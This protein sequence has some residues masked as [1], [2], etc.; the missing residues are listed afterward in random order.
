M[1]Y[2]MRVPAICLAFLMAAA[3]AD[4]QPQ[5]LR[6]RGICD[7]FA[8]VALGP[9]HFV[10]AEDEHDILAIY[11]CGNAT[12]VATVDISDF[13]GNRKSNGK[14]K[15]ADIEGAARIGNRIY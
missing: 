6:Y 10:V 8:A 11:R 15:E 2:V 14:I 12:P 5:D 1:L 3:L 4:T 7:A 9:N 13:L